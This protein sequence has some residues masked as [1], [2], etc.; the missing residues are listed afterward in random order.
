MRP[1]GTADVVRVYAEAS[2]QEEADELARKVAQATWRLAAGV[3][4]QPA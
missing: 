2:T 4:E 3:G 1:S